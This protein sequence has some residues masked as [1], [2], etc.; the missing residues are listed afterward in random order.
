M[1]AFHLR[2]DRRLNIVLDGK[3]FPFRIPE[4]LF[5]DFRRRAQVQ[6]PAEDPRLLLRPGAPAS[7]GGRFC[8]RFFHGIQS[9]VPLTV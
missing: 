4:H 9:I 1:V 3:P 5:V 6:V 7:S 8:C 2:E